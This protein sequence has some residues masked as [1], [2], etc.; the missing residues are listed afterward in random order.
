[1]TYKTNR[2]HS[3]RYGEQRWEDNGWEV[4]H[5]PTGPFTD[6]DSGAEEGR[7]ASSSNEV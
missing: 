5:P 4:R 3:H 1:M 6:M 7:P 2:V